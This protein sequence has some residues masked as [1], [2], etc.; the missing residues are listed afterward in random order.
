MKTQVFAYV[1]TS[2]LSYKKA[3]ESDSKTRQMRA[4]RT[5]CRGK[6]FSIKETYY[7]QSVSGSNGC[8]LTER[9]AFSEML[10]E[11][12]SNGVKTFV[13]AD[14]Q[15]YSRSIVTAAIISEEL[16]KHDLR[17]FDASTGRDLANKDAESPEEQLIANILFCV[18]EFDRLK[19]NSRLMSG[20]LRKRKQGGYIGGTKAF[21][22]E[23]NDKKVIARIKEL[24]KIFREE[25]GKRMTKARIT[26]ILSDEGFRTRKGTEFSVQGITKIINSLKL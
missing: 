5:F 13:V 12:K 23:E 24:R 22:E 18:S 15:R 17:A 8:D 21:G 7:D 4:I 25:D 16:K 3:G 2:N 10:A 6:G 20:K 9:E 26:R 14:A 11:L 19:T 1:R